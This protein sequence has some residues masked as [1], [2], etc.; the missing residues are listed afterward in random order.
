MDA[1]LAAN[2]PPESPRSQREAVQN[3]GC[4]VLGIEKVGQ[5]FLPA[6]CCQA[7]QSAMRRQKWPRHLER[8]RDVADENETALSS[9]GKAADGFYSMTMKPLSTSIYTFEKLIEG[10]FLYVDKT[11]ILHELLSPAFAQYFIARPRRFGKSLLVSTLKAIFQGRRELFKGLHILENTDY[12]W[13]VHPVVHLDLG[14]AQAVDAAELDRK[15]RDLVVY[16]AELHQVA[17]PDHACDCSSAF[18]FLLRTLGRSGQRA[19]VLVDEYDKPILG[20]VDRPESLPEILRVLKGFY[21]VIKTTEEHQRFALLTGVSK[22]SK[23]SIFSDLNNLTDITLDAPYATLLGYTQDELETNFA[24]HLDHLAAT[25]QRPRQA[26]LDDI[27]DWY[28][29]YRF[30]HAAASVYNPVSV[31]S[32]LRTGE[33]RN[34]W[35]ETGTPSLLLTMLRDKGTDISQIEKMTLNELGF[36]A[37]E[38][39]KMRVEPLLFQTGYVTILGYDPESK[40]Y[41]L[42]YPNREIRD[43]FMQYLADTFTAVPKEYAQSEAYA[44]VQALRG[45]DVDAFMTRLQPFF[46]GI[47]YDLH[48]PAE[49]YYQTVF[50]LIVRL[51]GIY[52]RTEVKTNL[53]RIDAVAELADRVYIFEFKFDDSAAAALEQIRDR[54]YFERF[55]AGGKQ[56]ILVGAAFKTADRNVVDWQVEPLPR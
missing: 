34:Y 37:Y 25:G 14:S 31:M 33:F 10:G 55:L 6:D 50:Y 11:A 27:R 9:D 3:Q 20:T 17:I 26:L 44:L 19:V 45:G 36:S 40:L 53:G 1:W 35:F 43:A 41:T 39:S 18:L 7:Q 2:I 4:F 13:P 8:L 52:I 42:G 24:P 51:L 21:S 32:L 30:H 47:D 38:V 15:L 23:V 22:F 46:A 48:I 54:R 16:S 56:I 28:N 29:G 49:K 5:T 12:G